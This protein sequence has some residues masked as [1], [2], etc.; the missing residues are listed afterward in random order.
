MVISYGIALSLPV[1]LVVLLNTPSM[2]VLPTPSTLNLNAGGFAH[3]KR[4]IVA[5][6]GRFWIIPKLLLP[7]QTKSRQFAETVHFAP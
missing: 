4:C 7:M 1:T 6:N 5:K 3:G 2:M